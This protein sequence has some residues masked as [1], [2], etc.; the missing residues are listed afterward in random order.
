LS[1]MTLQPGAL[2]DF[3]VSFLPTVV[4]SAGATLTI[5]TNAVNSTVLTLTGVG[6]KPELKLDRTSIFFGDARVGSSDNKVPITVTNTGN[7]PVNVQSLPVSGPF[8][9][10]PGTTLPY[11]VPIGQSFT[12]EVIFRPSAQG[13]ATGSVTVISDITGAATLKVDLTG[14]GTI[15]VASLSVTEIDFGSQR[16][17]AT[18]GVQ[19]VIITNT[20]QARLEI[21]EIIFSNPAFTLSA[22]LPLPTPA[23]KLEIAAG[24]QK[25]LSVTFTPST[26]GATEGKLFIISNAFTPAPALTLKG[27]GVDGQMSLDPSVVDSSFAGVEVGGSGAQKI[28]TLTNSGEAS[29]TILGV[30]APTNNSFSVSGLPEGLVLQPGA[31]WPFTVTFTPTRRGYVSASTVIASDARMNPS[32]SLALEGTGVAAALDL[33]PKVVSFPSSNV[34][35]ATTQNISIKNAGE[36][37]LYVANIVFLDTAT[38]A[39]GAALDFT[40]QGTTFPLVVAPGQSTLVPLTFKPRAAGGRQAEA[41]VLTNDT[42]PANVSRATLT[43][44]GTSPTLELSS[45][46]L[47]NGVLKFGN[48]LVGTPSS[49]RT[50]KVTNRG[51]GPLTLSAMS[52]GGADA[53]AYILTPPTLPL[54]L[55]PGSST[56]ISLA[57]KPDV[58]RPFSAQL[59]MNSNDAN[60]LS[61]VVPLSGLG[62]RQ[63]I[64]LSE[65]SLEFGNLLVNN[66]SSLRKVT[67]TNNS[68]TNVTLTALS[69]EG[70][71]APQFSL[72]TLPL[73]LILAPSQEQEVGLYFTPQSEADVNCVLKITFSDLPAP[74]E[75]ALHGKGI[76]AVLSIRPAPLD[77]GG[78]RAGGAQRDLPLTLTNL[79]SEPIILTAPVVAYSTGELFTYDGASLNGL[80]LKPGTPHILTVSYQP[81]GETLSETTLAFGTL[82]PNEPRAVE[83]QVKGKA[84]SRLL[85]VDIN[86]LDFGRV[87]VNEPVAPRTITISNKS[88]QQQRVEVKLKNADTPYSLDT[89]SLIDALPANGSATFTVSFSPSAAG[90]V[91]NEVQVFLQNVPEA[92]ALIPVTGNGRALMGSGGGCSTTQFQVSSAGL[93]A[94]LALVALGSRRRRRE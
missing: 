43:G 21:T 41:V 67:V 69:V 46:Y 82:K 51:N 7:A 8:A 53:A 61:V 49:P 45:T 94:L 37:D 35:V 62:V 12:F 71:G 1:A 30:G 93:L 81:R 54:T 5:P 24:E 19:P 27:K 57:L 40:A 90:P 17:T 58:D 18:S 76:P 59:V 9:V 79:S 89:R 16:V 63:Q 66:K 34:G 26:L 15:S 64:Q 65:S 23:R 87:D 31:Q 20:G 73:P 14:T 25:A 70:A 83:V 2:I 38:G 29:L 47:D 11:P 13:P 91:D 92:E 33:Q 77:F 88:G 56:E 3:Q 55:Q 42:D 74:L 10:A 52:L 48:V 80:E 50:L 39:P 32:F 44:V 78:V 86:S 85:T 72:A 84:T 6:A 75:V 36:R 60:A 4:G 28:V 68:D 22:P